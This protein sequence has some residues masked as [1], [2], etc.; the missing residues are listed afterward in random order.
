MDSKILPKVLYIEDNEQERHLVRRLLEPS[1]QV[2]EASD[3]LSGIDLAKSALP[4][5][6]LLDIH[7]PKMTGH[8]AAT[9]LKAILPDTPLVAITAHQPTNARERALAAGFAGFIPKPID[10]EKFSQQVDEYLKGKREQLP[11]AETHLRQY[12]GELVEHLEARVRELTTTVT[13]N[14]HLQ[15]ANQEMINIL[16]RSQTMLEAGARVSHGITS[17]LDLNDL[18]NS[19]VDI[20]CDEFHLYYSGIFLLSE[21]KK[22]AD[23]QAGHGEAGAAMIAEHYQLPVNRD[24]MIGI[25]ILDKAAGIALDVEGEPSH[26]KNPHLPDTRSEVALP[27]IFKDEVLG[28]LSIQSSEGNAFS[29]EDTTSLQLLADQIA[30]AI[31][32]AQLLR[33]LEKANNELVRSKTFEAIA[34]ATGEAIHWVGNKAAPLPGSVRRLR[35]DLLNLIAVFRTLIPASPASAKVP[36]LRGVVENI[37]DEASAQNIDLNALANELMQLPEKRRNALLSLESMLEDFQI[38]ENSANTILTIKE[39]LIGPARQRN[40]CPILLTEALPRLVGNMG[41]PK[42]VVSFNLPADLPPILGDPRQVDQ[43]FNNLI[44][45]AWEALD[46]N[47][48][49]SILIRAHQDADPRYVL[50]SV[51]DNGPGIPP[52]V[53]EKI[54]VSFFTTKSGHGGTGLG[55]SACLE[56]V[57]QNGGNIWVES[58]A[59]KGAKFYVLLPVASN[60]TEEI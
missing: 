2:L 21:D 36:P 54:W 10:A 19:T 14:Y 50:V 41:V 37:F 16:I 11:D 52:E 8:E 49:P 3:P 34:T 39:D 59:G 9:R 58:Q 33:Q 7:L 57:R 28:A 4:D 35:G 24:S 23:L 18:L 17:I 15:K 55:W 45:N 12:Q 48:A 46:E 56:I 29:Q 6:V 25:V 31:H 1:Y 22:F 40:P 47:P 44:K 13:R 30:I 60:R 27:L 32:N 5:I 43:V 38:I 42:C 51:Q 20:I 53:Q 26:F